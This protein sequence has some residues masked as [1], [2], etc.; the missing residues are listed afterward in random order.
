MVSTVALKVIYSMMSRTNDI[1]FGWIDFVHFRS[2]ECQ[3]IVLEIAEGPFVA[4]ADLMLITWRQA[5]QFWA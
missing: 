4:K 1:D 3:K 2:S 5:L